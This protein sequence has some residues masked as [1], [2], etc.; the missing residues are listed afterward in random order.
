MKPFLPRLAF[1]SVIALLLTLPALADDN[2]LNVKCVDQSGAGI[3]G[4]EVK[5]QNLNTNKFK[6]K[7]SDEAGLAAFNKLDDGVYR[8]MARKQGLAPAFYEYAALKNAGQETVTLRFEPGDHQKLVYFEDPA[9][10]QLAYDALKRGVEALQG[11]KWADAEKELHS[12]IEINPSNPEARF[13]LAVAYLQQRKWEAA[14]EQLKA[15]K[16]LSNALATVP[17]QNPQAGAFYAELDSRATQ[18]MAKLPG[19]KLR[20]LGDKALAEKKF[21]EAIVKY[22][23]AIKAD[24]S[25]PDLYYNLALA[26]ANAKKL[27]DSAA[28]IDKAL[29]LKPNESAYIKLKQQIAD[30]KQNEILAKAKSILEEGDKLYQG[31]DHAGALKKYEEALPIVPEKNQAGI[32]RQMGNTQ[33]KL[34]NKD[35]AVKAFKRAIELN[36][37]EANNKKALAQFYMNEKMYDEALEI[38]AD[39][40][41]AGSETV[42]QTLFRLGKEL[43]QKGNSEVAQLAFEKVIKVNPDNAE[44][45]YELGTLYFYDRKDNKRAQEMLTKYVEIGKDKDHVNNATSLLVVISRKK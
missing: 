37:Q 13:N 9:T 2:T 20:D 30:Y 11:S 7:K 1:A 28:T 39:P 43:S 4:V 29:A 26:Q 22:Q 44:A 17:S 19:L 12:S 33:A 31:G 32:W 8:V 14:E 5:I 16:S 27:D 18:V 3:N 21:D 35:E 23:D 34:G 36:P 6:D 45:Y 10:N 25:D 24:P 41:T 42:D 15:V 40:A 38:Y